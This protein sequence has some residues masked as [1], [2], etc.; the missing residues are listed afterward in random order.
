[1]H[2]MRVN[3]K[4]MLDVEERT[5]KLPP[6]AEGKLPND[7]WVKTGD[8][9]TYKLSKL[10]Q[11]AASYNPNYGNQGGEEISV[12]RPVRRKKYY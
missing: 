12:I 8:K 9:I 3:V 2:G 10:S 7:G 6:E 5:Q 11:P 1:M 4:S